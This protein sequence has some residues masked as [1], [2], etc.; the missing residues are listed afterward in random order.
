MAFS[1]N[2][3][4]DDAVRQRRN[5]PPIPTT[6]LNRR[7]DDNLIGPELPKE[8]AWNKRTRDWWDMWRRSEIAPRLENSD[9]EHLLD[10]A[11]LHNEYWSRT[12]SLGNMVSYAAEI[13]RRVAA[14][15]AT[16][17]DRLKLRIKF[18]DTQEEEKTELSKNG[19][20]SV[21]SYKDLLE[22]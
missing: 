4:K 17:E 6:I 8:Y 20:S 22:E 9:W 15:G 14:F 3:P 11:N 12:L 19:K 18:A 10:T 16:L 7:T 13:R 21:S 1:Q 5:A 2:I